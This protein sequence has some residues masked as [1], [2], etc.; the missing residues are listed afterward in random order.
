MPRRRAPKQ[1]DIEDIVPIGQMPKPKPKPKPKRL[2]Q[3]RTINAD[4]ILKRRA[5]ENEVL[6]DRLREIDAQQAKL[7]DE[8]SEILR[9]L[10]DVS[11]SA[12]PEPNPVITEAITDALA[13]GFNEPP[14]VSGEYVVCIDCNSPVLRSTVSNPRL[15]C[16]VCKAAP[17]EEKK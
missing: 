7:N 2:Q 6:R 16:P 9:A 13:G 3:K 1:T 14:K 15:G 17:F 10:G 12:P 8:V 5:R 4:E 11:P